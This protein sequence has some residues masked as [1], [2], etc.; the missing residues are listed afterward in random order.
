MRAR[1]LASRVFPGQIIRN[2]IGC[3]LPK[4]VPR[5]L[6]VQILSADSENS[7]ALGLVSVGGCQ[8]LANVISFQLSE[9]A[10]LLSLPLRFCSRNDATRQVINIDLPGFS[11][12]DGTFNDVGKLSSISRKIIMRES[13][14]CCSGYTADLAT[15][16]KSIKTNEVPD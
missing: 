13:F 1:S 15:M 16:L 3:L 10:R 11:N 12:D 7:G 2:R 8:D 5:D 14:K 9:T 6:L 4:S